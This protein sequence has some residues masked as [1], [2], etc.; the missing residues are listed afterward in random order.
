MFRLSLLGWK[1]GAAEFAASVVAP[2]DLVPTPAQPDEGENAPR[3]GA[4]TASGPRATAPN[5]SDGLIL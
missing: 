3:V 1:M 5:G 2:A 4:L